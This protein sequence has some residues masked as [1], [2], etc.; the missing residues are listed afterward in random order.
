MTRYRRILAAA[1]QRLLVVACTAFISIFLL[2][3]LSS[4]AL[5]SNFK[6]VCRPPVP[7]QGP[8]RTLLPLSGE[9]CN[10]GIMGNN[11][12]GGV[13]ATDEIEVINILPGDTINFTF[14][15]DETPATF[16]NTVQ[17]GNGNF[18]ESGTQF[19]SSIV[20]GQV[21]YVVV[22]PDQDINNGLK[23]QLQIPNTVQ[24]RQ[25]VSYTVSCTQ[26][27][28]Q[29]GFINIKKAL[30][31]TSDPGAPSTQFTFKLDGGEGIPL[32]ISSV[33]ATDETGPLPVTPNVSHTVQEFGPPANWTLTDIDCGDNQN[34]ATVSAA[35]GQI[36]TC[37]FT[38]KFEV[39][40]GTIKV[41]KSTVGGNRKFDFDISQPASPSSFQL[42]NGGEKIFSSLP[43]G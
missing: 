4:V 40:K 12:P 30:D 6:T 8:P 7:S 28:Q 41:K 3:V 31:P 14:T 39:P 13:Q 1:L 26:A 34:P 23:F 29:D 43:V 27:P 42:M 35:P 19:F 18:T 25:F 32:S 11:C 9:L 38:N 37:K 17:I 20:S 36:V 21:N 33:V 5:A 15:L 24:N 22:N 2:T 10:N 16:T